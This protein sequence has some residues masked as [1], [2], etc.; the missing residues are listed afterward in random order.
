MGGREHGLTTTVHFPNLDFMVEKVSCKRE[1]FFIAFHH[2]SDV[3][4]AIGQFFMLICRTI[5]ALAVREILGERIV[6]RPA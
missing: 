3:M 2:P 4:T 1:P 6:K 5:I